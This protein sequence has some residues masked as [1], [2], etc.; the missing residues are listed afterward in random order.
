MND[1]YMLN[2][3]SRIIKIPFR[4]SLVL[5]GMQGVSEL[6]LN[7]AFKNISLISRRGEQ[8]TKRER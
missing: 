8:V 1:G 2:G 3:F 5:F 4:V 7:A 6:L